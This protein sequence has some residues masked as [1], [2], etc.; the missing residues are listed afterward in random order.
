MPVS[1]NRDPDCFP[2]AS[3][4]LDSELQIWSIQFPS[5]CTATIQC[6]PCQNLALVVPL[7]LRMLGVGLSVSESYLMMPRSGTRGSGVWL[8]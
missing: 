5:D 4:E 1:E 6:Y 3:K 7:R 2:I 8:F